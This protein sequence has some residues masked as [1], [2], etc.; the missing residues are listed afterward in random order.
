MCR[1]RSGCICICLPFTERTARLSWEIGAPEVP[2]WVALAHVA[3]SAAFGGVHGEDDALALAKRALQGLTLG[4]TFP[5]PPNGPK[6]GLIV[7]L[8]GRKTGMTLLVCICLHDT[9]ICVYI[10]M[11]IYM[12]VC[13]YMHVS[14]Y[15]YL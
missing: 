5:K 3:V 8:Y 4:P 12:Y 11:H 15:T 14:V 7:V 13:V 1:C 2:A 6:K 10:Y 9:Y